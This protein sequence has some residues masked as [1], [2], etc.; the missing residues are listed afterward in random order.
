MAA[1][2]ITGPDSK[3]APIAPP[4]AA[5]TAK[6]PTAPAMI[7]AILAPRSAWSL[8]NGVYLVRALEIAERTVSTALV[9]NLLVS[10]LKVKNSESRT[11]APT[12]PATCPDNEP[13]SFPTPAMAL[14]ILPLASAA[15]VPIL[16]KAVPTLVAVVANLSKPAR[17]VGKLM[18]ITP[19]ILANT[20]C[21]FVKAFCCASNPVMKEPRAASLAFSEPL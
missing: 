2:A 14:F 13:W 11:V 3:S 15:L 16:V 20:R 8:S 17:K 4:T 19:A 6:A 9:S 5:T 7:V 12:V 21:V 1:A 18:F 10:S